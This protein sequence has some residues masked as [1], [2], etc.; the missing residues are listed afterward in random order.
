MSLWVTYCVPDR[1]GSLRD[2]SPRARLI[3]ELGRPECVEP[4]RLTHKDNTLKGSR[5]RRESRVFVVS[6]EKLRNDF[7]KIYSIV[8]KGQNWSW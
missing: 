6:I 7:F 3:N 2:K 8:K 5:E 1:V 4:S